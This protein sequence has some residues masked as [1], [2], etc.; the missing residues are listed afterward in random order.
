MPRLQDA[1]DCIL[2]QQFAESPAPDG[3]GSCEAT[4]PYSRYRGYPHAP[5]EQL[6]ALRIHGVTPEY[7]EGLRSEGLQNLTLDQVI[8]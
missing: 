4:D 5:P 1:F 2:Q 6:I 7:I 8:A 3:Y